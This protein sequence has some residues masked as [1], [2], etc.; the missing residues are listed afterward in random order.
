[1]ARKKWTKKRHSFVFAFLRVIFR[2]FTKLRYNYTAKKSDIKGPCVI[3]CNHTT[4]MD[5]FFVSLS[6]KAPIYFFASDDIFNIKVAS[7]IIRYLVAPIPKSKSM[8]DLQAVRDCLT[9]LK[10]GGAVGLF[11]EGNRT[12][13]GGQWEMTDA[14]A[15]LVKLSK[16]PLVLYNIEGG[17][18]TDPR[19]GT[20]IRK[21]K[22]TGYVKRVISSEEYKNMSVDELYEIICRELNV[23]VQRGEGTKFKSRKRAENIERVLYMCPKC[24][25]VSSIVSKGKRFSCRKCGAK[26]EYGEELFIS[27]KE[28]FDS[29]YDWHEWERSRLKEKIKNSDVFFSDFDVKFFES[30]RLKRKKKLLGDRISADTKGLYVFA[31][32]DVSK[33]FPFAEMDGFTAV[34]KRKFNFYYHGK[35]L[36]IK[37]GK[38]FCAL[39]YLHLYEGVKNV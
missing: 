7:P 12:L 2:P 32:G 5:P 11:P 13:S 19:W 26:W 8:S 16:A 4:T 36:Q 6:F 29:V 17:Y 9:V 14:A 1:M 31:D 35:T 20:K 18:G 23:A 33:F 10:E 38:K 3:M 21:G 39:K 25:A 22:M 37:G 28:P 34:G 30:V 24:N 27:P 15:K